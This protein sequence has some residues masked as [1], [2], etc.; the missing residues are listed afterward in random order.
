MSGL[1]ALL[2]QGAASLQA[3]QAWSAT[4]GQNLSNA[5]TPG[6]A[7]QRAELATALPAE[8]LG[9]SWIGRGV[10]LAGVTQSRDRFVEAQ[11][12]Q[13][14][15]QQSF[16][17]SEMSVLQGVSALDLDSGVQPAINDFYAKLRALAQNPGSQSYREAAVGSAKQLALSFNRTGAA[18]ASARSAVDEQVKGT[19]PEINQAAA[20]IATLNAKIREARVGGASPN[21]LLDARQRLGD[22]LA[23]LTGATAVANSNDDLNLVLPGGTP[24]VNG[25]HAATLTAVPDM[26]NGGHLAIWAT[27]PDGSAAAVVDPA[28]GGELGGAIAARDGALRTAQDALDQLA[29]DLSGAINTVHAAGYALDG[30]TGRDLFVTTATAAGAAAGLT[31]NA[32][33]SA[34]VSLLAASSSAA[35][36]PGDATN[37]QA[38]IDTEQQALSS[39]LDV[40][41]SVAQITSRYGADAKAAQASAE[42][43]GALLENVTALRAS[44]SGVSTDEELIDMQK[45]QRAYEATAKII[46]AADAMLETLLSIKTT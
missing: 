33:L 29:F 41:A 10:V 4:I 18:L 9:D 14:T 31:V 8:R 2:S 35:T 46:A 24:L 17:A 28:P 45:A 32:A 1:F 3:T 43:D 12:A 42:A 13:T 6:Y 38:I 25:N 39:G 15:G 30:T 37:L 7:R 19:L 20:Q 27:P 44:A 23:E 40:G 22:R 36:V 21:D 16:S 11:F 26:A 5:N 34:N